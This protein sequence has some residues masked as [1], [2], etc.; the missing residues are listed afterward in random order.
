MKAFGSGRLT[1]LNQAMAQRIVHRARR[2]GV[3]KA[4]KLVVSAHFQHSARAWE[5]CGWL[6]DR[7][8]D[9]LASA[10]SPIVHGLPVPGR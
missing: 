2:L 1:G 3:V 6:S 8:D 5:C 10:P 9:N 7:A 4:A